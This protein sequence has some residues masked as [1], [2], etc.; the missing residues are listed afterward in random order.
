MY[1]KQPNGF[2]IRSYAAQ[3]EFRRQ[4]RFIGRNARDSGY[5]FRDGLGLQTAGPD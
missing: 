2:L 3:Q 4:E 1:W 5:I